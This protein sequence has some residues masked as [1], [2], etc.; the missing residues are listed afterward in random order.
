MKNILVIVV[1]LVFAIGLAGLSL[2]GDMPG[3]IH[4]NQTSCQ[5]GNCG[6]CCGQKNDSQSTKSEYKTP[7]KKVIDLQPNSDS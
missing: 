5:M 2:A 4:G 6:T 3:M 7:A 1:A